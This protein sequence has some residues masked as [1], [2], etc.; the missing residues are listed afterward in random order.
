MSD[1]SLFQSNYKRNDS[2]VYASGHQLADMQIVQNDIQNM[3]IDLDSTHSDTY[4]NQ[5]SADFN[6]HYQITGYYPLVAF[7]G[8]TGMFLG[9]ELRPCNTYTSRNAE[10]FLTN[11]V[12]H[13]SKHPCNMNVIVRVDSGF[14][15][16]VIYNFCNE[17]DNL[18]VIRLKANSRLR[19]EAERYIFLQ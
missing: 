13:F 8:L 4:G 3:V 6:S 9:A 14:A 5:E 15:K 11:I 1:S 12:T 17:K 19:S 2:S 7:D 18:F 10:T 16:P